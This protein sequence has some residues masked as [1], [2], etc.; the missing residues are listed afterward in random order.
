MVGLESLS[1]EEKALTGRK[2]RVGAVH[3]GAR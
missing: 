3:M 2:G 1:E